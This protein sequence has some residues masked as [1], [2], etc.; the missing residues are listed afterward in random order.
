MSCHFF[1]IKNGSISMKKTVDSEVLYTHQYVRGIDGTCTKTD[2]ENCRASL[3]RC[4][5]GSKTFD[6]AT[7][8]D[9]VFSDGNNLI[10]TLSRH[11]GKTLS[12]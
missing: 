7:V 8:E 9:I 1:E 2:I 4:L 11:P 5:F 10:R 12:K 3:Q 6:T